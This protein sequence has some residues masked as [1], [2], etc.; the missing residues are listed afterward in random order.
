MVELEADPD[1][2]VVEMVDRRVGMVLAHRYRIVHKLAAGGFGAVY[3]AHDAVAGCDVAVKLLH[4][5]LVA[6]PN[7]AARFRR[8]VEALAS[9]TSPHTVAALDAGEA[10]DGTPFLVMELLAGESVYEQMKAHGRMPWPRVVAIA[11]GVCHSLGEAHSLGIVH[12]DLK[13]ENIHLERRGED[14]DFV[15]VLDFGIAKIDQ[16]SL[17]DGAELTQVGQMVGTFAYMAPEQM[18]G[19]CTAAS[20]V[21]TLGVVMYELIAGR[22]PYGKAQGPAA[23]LAAVLADDPPPLASAPPALAS[24]IARCIDKDPRRRYRDAVALG[25]ALAQLGGPGED[26]PTPRVTPRSLGRAA[27]QPG[28]GTTLHGIAPLAPA[29]GP[30]ARGSSPDG[31]VARGDASLARLS[32]LSRLAA[33]TDP[34]T[35]SLPTSSF[36]EAPTTATGISSFATVNWTAVTIAVVIAAA[37]IALGIAI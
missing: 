32:R 19:T 30:L 14:A 26:A 23:Q 1:R 2:T 24:L 12:R 27:L 37:L 29:P 7:I 34:I 17:E 15:K 33:G 9:L 8:E 35:S 6:D 4:P 25:A 16:S 10:P 18:V 11:R 28:L 21:F 22:R 20:D 31:A 36:A 5:G 3:V 13:P